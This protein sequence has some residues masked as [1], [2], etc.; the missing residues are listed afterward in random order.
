MLHALTQGDTGCVAPCVKRKDGGSCFT[1][2]RTKFE[3]GISPHQK[4]EK[5]KYK[6]V[7]LTKQLWLNINDLTDEKNRALMKALEESDKLRQR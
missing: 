7:S 5:A 4:E 2:P 1:L 3:G 6:Y